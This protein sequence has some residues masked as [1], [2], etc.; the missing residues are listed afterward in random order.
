MYDGGAALRTYHWPKCARSASSGGERKKARFETPPLSLSLRLSRRRALFRLFSP[1][2]PSL[3]SMLQRPPFSIFSIDA[4]VDG[5]LLVPSSSLKSTRSECLLKTRVEERAAGTA[6]RKPDV[7]R[8]RTSLPWHVKRAFLF[9]PPP[10]ARPLRA[11]S[12]RRPSRIAL[13]EDRQPSVARADEQRSGH[14]S[15]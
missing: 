9:L 5:V 11:G 12:F 10:F 8:T 6:D 2:L 4:V 3:P 1:P 14:A 13:M 15:L 7:L